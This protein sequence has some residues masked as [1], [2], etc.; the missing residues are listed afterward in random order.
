MGSTWLQRSTG[1]R[2]DIDCMAI[3]DAYHSS[4]NRPYIEKEIGRYCKR[5]AAE[6]SAILYARAAFDHPVPT[7]FVMGQSCGT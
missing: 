3:A 4:E 5:E 6:Y 1:E 7:T 2:R